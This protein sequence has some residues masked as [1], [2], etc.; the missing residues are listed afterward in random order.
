MGDGLLNIADAGEV[1]DIKPR[2]PHFPAK[3]K[4]VI[5]LCMA[6]QRLRRGALRQLQHQC[7]IDDKESIRAKL[8]ENF[9][10]TAEFMRNKEG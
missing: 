8:L 5:H 6:A 10:N 7:Q 2:A 4:R 9:F 1:V 3:A